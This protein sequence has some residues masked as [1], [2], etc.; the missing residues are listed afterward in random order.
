MH[1][2]WQSIEVPPHGHMIN[3]RVESRAV[4]W[5]WHNSRQMSSMCYCST[6]SYVRKMRKFVNAEEL[7]FIY[8]SFFFPKQGRVNLMKTN[9]LLYSEHIKCCHISVYHEL[10]LLK[11]WKTFYCQLWFKHLKYGLVWV[12]TQSMISWTVS[13]TF[14]AN[15]LLNLSSSGPDLVKRKN[16][17]DKNWWIL[18]SCRIC[19]NVNLCL[20]LKLLKKKCLVLV[21]LWA[22][23]QAYW[24]NHINC[25]SESHVSEI[26]LIHFHLH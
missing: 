2:S 6:G 26:V 18:S 3:L 5:D 16:W 19:D 7:V 24:G 12:L 17:K 1:H 20:N 8:E 25:T 21:K 9:D 23:S 10:A 13:H 15:G 22:E 11:W 4:F 14:F